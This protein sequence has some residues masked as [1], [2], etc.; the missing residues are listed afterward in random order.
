[1]ATQ[2]EQP[3]FWLIGSEP[4]VAEYGVKAGDSAIYVR[5]IDEAGRVGA[6]NPDYKSIYHWVLDLFAEYDECP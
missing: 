5:S 4:G 6:F 3:E 1:M 2:Q